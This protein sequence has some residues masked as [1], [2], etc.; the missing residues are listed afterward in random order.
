MTPATRRIGV[1]TSGG[2]CPGLNAAIRAITRRAVSGHGYEVLGIED[3]VAGLATGRARPLTPSLLDLDGYDPML[4]TG[5]TILGSI[6]SPIDAMASEIEAGYDSL[7]L[8]ALI[9][10]GG[11]GSLAIL[12]EHARSG[13]NL[14]AIPK[15]IDNDVAL[16]DQSIGF[17]SAVRTV[18]QACSQLRSTGVSHDRVMIL[19]TMGRGAG[20]LALSSGIAGGAD[21][22]LIPE[23]PWSMD[24]LIETVKATCKRRSQAFALVVVAEGAAPPGGRTVGADDQSQRRIHGG[25]GEAIAVELEERTGGGVEARA[26]VLGH[27]QRGGQPSP[28]D[29]ILATEYGIHAVDL[30]A[31]NRFDTMVALRG[32]RIEPVPLRD[33]VAAGSALVDPSEELAH[34]AR[35]VGIYLGDNPLG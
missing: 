16:T 18:T 8:D 23:I 12:Q 9:A 1:M 21:A 20:H 13:W 11:D 15:T 29:T 27:L 14:V 31:Q 33:V 35:S 24:A 28:I 10:I 4:S 3:A 17:D 22:I 25:V 30:V 26:T 34:T 32:T 7:G 5:G 2:D 19:E 6:N